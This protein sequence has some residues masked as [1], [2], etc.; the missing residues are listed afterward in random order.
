MKRS[1]KKKKVSTRC[2]N[3]DPPPLSFAV[4]QKRK[5]T[6]Y[7]AQFVRFQ[8][9]CIVYQNAINYAWYS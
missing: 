2:P 5:Q 8:T 9:F 6:V 1:A 4:Y 3:L 7:G